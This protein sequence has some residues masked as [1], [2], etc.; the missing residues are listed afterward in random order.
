MSQ[1]FSQLFYGPPLVIASVLWTITIMN[2]NRSLENLG[3][4]HAFN[5]TIFLVIE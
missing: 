4:M 5:F 1:T 2:F 3:T